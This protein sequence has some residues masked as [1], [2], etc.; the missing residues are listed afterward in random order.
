MMSSLKLNKSERLVHKLSLPD[1][2]LRTAGL[3]H[4]GFIDILPTSEKT[5]M[6]NFLQKSRVSFLQISK[7]E[8]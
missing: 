7:V 6:I 4:S 5:G 1:G 2:V 8:H 3:V